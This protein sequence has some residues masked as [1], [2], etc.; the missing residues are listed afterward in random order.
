MTSTIVSLIVS[1]LPPTGKVGKQELLNLRTVP[2]VFVF[3]LW[4]K[5]L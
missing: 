1:E 3:E 4:L 5:T 2:A